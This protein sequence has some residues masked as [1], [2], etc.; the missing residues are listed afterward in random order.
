MRSLRSRYATLVDALTSIVRGWTTICCRAPEQE[1][2]RG[3]RTGR[4]VVLQRP[5]LGWRDDVAHGD[6]VDAT[7]R[8]R[9][10]VE[11]EEVVALG[12]QMAATRA[13]DDAV[14]N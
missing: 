13:V 9:R 8:N 4:P 14:P 11:S 3:R 10:G 7:L 5:E 12:L 2:M 6:P 1:G